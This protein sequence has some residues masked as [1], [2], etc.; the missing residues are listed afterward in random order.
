MYV[1]VDVVL[2]DVVVCVEVDSVAVVACVVD[3]CGIVIR[4]V[5]VLFRYD[6]IV[7]STNNGSNMVGKECSYD[8]Q[9]TQPH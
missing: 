4:V 5:V 8:T 3:T 1:V 7:L 9:H 6:V 2:D